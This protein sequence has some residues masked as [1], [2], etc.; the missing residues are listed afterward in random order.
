MLL[1][2]LLLLLWMLFPLQMLFLPWPWFAVTQ[3]PLEITSSVTL[4][5]GEER[6]ALNSCRE[7]YED[8]YIN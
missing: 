4:E 5:A 2:E 1:F 7:L 6:P 3:W 8:T